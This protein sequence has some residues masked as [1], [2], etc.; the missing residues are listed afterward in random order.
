MRLSRA[1]LCYRPEFVMEALAM[2]TDRPD[3]DKT[4]KAAFTPLVH[5]NECMHEVPRSE[6]LSREGSDYTLFFC[7][8][9]CFHRWRKGHPEEAA[10]LHGHNG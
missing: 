9:D 8:L 10:R 2:G 6:A 3:R 1:V 4:N 7:G 5:C